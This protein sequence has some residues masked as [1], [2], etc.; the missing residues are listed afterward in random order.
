MS[1]LS[2]LLEKHRDFLPELFIVSH[3]SLTSAAPPAAAAG[4]RESSLPLAVAVRP[5]AEGGSV[6][7]PRCWRWRPRR[8]APTGHG[9]LCSRCREALKS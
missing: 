3:V 2:R 5:A 1:P 7:C 6:R 8:L 9:E 4:A